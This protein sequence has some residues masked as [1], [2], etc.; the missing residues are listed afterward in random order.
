MIIPP[1]D[2]HSCAS[3]FAPLLFWPPFQQGRFCFIQK[4]G[5]SIKYPLGFSRQFQ[6][7]AVFGQ[8]KPSHLPQKTMLR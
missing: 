7:E 1:G 2:F 6:K 3:V 8:E 5:K 4:L